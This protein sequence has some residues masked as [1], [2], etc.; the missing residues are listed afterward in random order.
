L[1]NICD[2]LKKTIAKGKNFKSI[3]NLAYGFLF[4]VISISGIILCS[5]PLAL[6]AAWF[7]AQVYYTKKND[8]GRILGRNPDKSLKSF[9]PCYPKS[10]L[11]LCL[12][13]SFSSN[14]TYSYSFYSVFLYTVKEKGGNLTENQIPSL[15]FK[16]SI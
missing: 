16:K 2:F 9:P 5:A 13:I 7:P 8:K 1:P 15:W 11:Q 6:S 4:F 12:E 3:R 10:P 14:S